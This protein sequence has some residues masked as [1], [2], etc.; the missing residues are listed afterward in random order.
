MTTN[1]ETSPVNLSQTEQVLD[2]QE[3]EDKDANWPV[4]IESSEENES[5]GDNVDDKQQIQRG[6]TDGE[7][8]I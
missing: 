5:A 4:Y 1:E 3:K 6:L 7:G 8:F 2:T